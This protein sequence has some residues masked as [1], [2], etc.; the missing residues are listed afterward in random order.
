M[1]E[2]AQDFVEIA[3]R[4]IHDRD[5][6]MAAA[7]EILAKTDTSTAASIAWA[8]LTLVARAQARQPPTRKLTWR[9]SQI[10]KH[11]RGAT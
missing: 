9:L 10:R 11:P 1:G 8:V 3:N 5:D 2:P 6:S 7:R 4:P